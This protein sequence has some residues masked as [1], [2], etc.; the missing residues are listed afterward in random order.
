MRVRS[1][2]Y[3]QM[4][5]VKRGLS[6]AWLGTEPS[7]A[8]VLYNILFFVD[9]LVSTTSNRVITVPEICIAHF[10]LSRIPKITL[11]FSAN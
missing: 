5:S 2:W 6:V 1:V 4:S 7:S 11:W 3:L 8:T 9:Q 10:V